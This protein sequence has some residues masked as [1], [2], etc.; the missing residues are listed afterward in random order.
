MYK[1]LLFNFVFCQCTFAWNPFSLFSK[2]PN[3]DIIQ[4]EFPLNQNGKVSIKN[5]WGNI[6]VTTWKQDMVQI[7]ITKSTTKP[8]FVEK[9]SVNIRASEKQIIIE[10]KEQRDAAGKVEVLIELIVPQGAQVNAITKKGAI[11]IKGLQAPA[12]ARTE[13][14]NIEIANVQ[15]AIVT[16]SDYG[17]IEIS[18]SSEDIRAHTLNGNIT[19]DEAG[20]NIVA[21]TKKGAIRTSCK[22]VEQLDTVSLSTKS[23]NIVLDLPEQVNAELL[24]KTNKGKIISEHFIT[25][26]PQTT[27]L[28]KKNWARMRK[29][30]DGTLGSGDASIKLTAG[31]GNIKINKLA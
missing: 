5:I 17:N 20:R 13:N 6:N 22:K 19:I 12:K 8:E 28:N 4:K 7:K 14:G 9:V 16:S 26:K 24:A 31:S 30:I 25:I 21:R 10:T 11:S 18:S 15:G 3:E 23:G 2:K 1:I 29:E 27:Q